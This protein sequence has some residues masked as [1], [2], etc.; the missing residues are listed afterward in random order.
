[1]VS[2]EQFVELLLEEMFRRWAADTKR[3][4]DAEAMLRTMLEI[5]EVAS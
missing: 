1:M 5:E 3:A 2:D 4:D